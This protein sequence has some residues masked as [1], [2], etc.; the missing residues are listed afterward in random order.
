VGWAGGPGGTGTDGLGTG[1]TGTD[2]LGTGGTGTDGLGTGGTG[3]AGGT[4]GLGTGGTGTTGAGTGGT[5]TA[6]IL[7][8]GQYV[9]VKIDPATYTL[10]STSITASAVFVETAFMPAE[11]DVVFL[12][13]FPTDI[14][15]N[16]FNLG[17]IPVNAGS[18]TM[19]EAGQ[20]IAVHGTFTNGVVNADLIHPAAGATFT[21]GAVNSISTATS[22]G[23]GT[24]GFG[25]STMVVNGITFDISSARIKMNGIAATIDDVIAG[26]QVIVKSPANNFRSLISGGTGTDGLGTGGTGTDGLGTGGTGTDGLGTGGT[27]TDGLGTGGTGTSPAGVQQVACPASGTTDVTI[28]DFLFSPASITVPANTTVKWTNNGPSVHTVTSNAGSIATFDSGEF[29]AGSS[30]CFS[31]AD[32]GTFD[33]LCTLHPFMTGS[34]TVQAGTDGL[35]SGGTGTDGLGTGGTGTGA[36]TG[37]TGT[38]AVQKATA[39]WII[40]NMTGPASELSGSITS[41]LSGT[42]GNGETASSATFTIFGQAVRIDGRTK[43]GPELTNLLSSSTGS[44]AGLDTGAVMNASGVTDGMGSLLAT[45]IDSRPT[46]TEYQVRGLVSGVTGSPVSTFTLTPVPDGEPLTVSLL[47][48][49]TTTG[50]VD[51]ATVNVRIDPASFGTIG[52]TSVTASAVDPVREPVPS[53]NDIVTVEGVVSDLSGNTFIV[54]G[55]NVDAGTVPTTGLSE[56]DRVRVRG[57]ISGGTIIADQIQVI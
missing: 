11:G 35:G 48:G 3:T 15:G 25:S 13:G 23:T 1:G 17:G 41:T 29:S 45:F 26:K 50:I 46:A 22:E 37:G 20:R 33:Y 9:N 12:E 43:F 6:T 55:M 53:E 34:V 38:T 14:S 51:G 44:L 31:F 7:A 56:S 40:D 10:G 8:D 36:G 4:G 27:G 47:S 18:L 2:G 57:T 54:N 5:G 49:M 42:A 24:N 30:V 21:M 16:T 32:P 19:P 39:V 52:S 28:Q